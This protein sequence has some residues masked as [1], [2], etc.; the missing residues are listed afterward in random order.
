MSVSTLSYGPPVAQAGPCAHTLSL[1]A[2][3]PGNSKKEGTTLPFATPG[4]GQVLTGLCVFSVLGREGQHGMMGR[5]LPLSEG[6][7]EEGRN[8]HRGRILVEGA[9]SQAGHCEG[10]WCAR[11]AVGRKEGRREESMGGGRRE[12]GKIGEGERL[13]E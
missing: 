4:W 11:P 5:I 9:E 8:L 6:E 10:P 2:K 13:G 1:P 7:A 12:E 3:S